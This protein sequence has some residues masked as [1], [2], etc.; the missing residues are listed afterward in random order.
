MFKYLA[1]VAAAAAL[2]LAGDCPNGANAD[3]T[4]KGAALG[5]VAKNA[6]GSLAEPAN[7]TA[8]LAEPTNATAKSLGEKEGETQQQKKNLAEP[9]N[10]TAT[11]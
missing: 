5:D 8:S 10:A 9:R 11:F 6:T 4:C 7:K 1:L 3:G 2:R